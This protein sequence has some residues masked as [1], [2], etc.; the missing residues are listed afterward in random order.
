MFEAE[1]DMQVR[2]DKPPLASESV[3]RTDAKTIS[4]ILSWHI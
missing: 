2:P 4:R 1:R 3:W